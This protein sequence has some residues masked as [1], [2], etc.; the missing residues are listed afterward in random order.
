MMVGDVKEAMQDLTAAIDA[1][2]Y[3]SHAYFNRANLHR[4][5]GNLQA[6]R[7]DYEMSKFRTLLKF[8]LECETCPD[9]VMYRCEAVAR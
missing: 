3:S 5:H 4:Y 2:C 7:D 8:V 6:A 1:N 9:N